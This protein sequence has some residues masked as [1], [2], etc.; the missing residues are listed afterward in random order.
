MP[1]KKS[2]GVRAEAGSVSTGRGTVR[3]IEL[4]DE[5][6]NELFDTD[7]PAL[8]ASVPLTDLLATINAE[9][10]DGKVIVEKIVRGAPDEWL[11]E[12][13]PSG[14]LNQQLQSD[15][16]AGRYRVRVYARNN[17]GLLAIRANKTI[18][19]GAL[20][21]SKE[22]GVVATQSPGADRVAE[23]MAEMRAAADKAND[24]HMTLMN[25]VIT[26]LAGNGNRN[27]LAE[28]KTFADG[29]NA[30]P[31]P[32]KE[33]NPIELLG[34]VLGLVERLKAAGGP[35][36][37]IDAETGDVGSNALLM[38]GIEVFGSVLSAAKGA[39]GA[40]QAPALAA[41]LAPASPPVAA[42]PLA[43]VAPQPPEDEDMQMVRLFVRSLV[44]AARAGQPVEAHANTVYAA[45]S[46]EALA[47]MRQ[48]SWFETLGAIEPI[49][50][51][52]RPWFAALRDEVLA[53]AAEESAAPGE[54]ADAGSTTI[55]T[56]GDIRS[57]AAGNAAAAPITAKR[58]TGGA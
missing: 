34:A 41:P 15:Y 2:N 56:H 37:P 20:P 12:G 40:P 46:D 50:A 45:L 9:G 32:A 25:T 24:R 5:M 8:N 35:A 21:K 42:I 58:K 26:A 53:Y 13:A 33:Q 47:A 52:L 27:Q 4:P 18:T 16:G 10:L 57:Q 38:K 1:R 36:L 54:A 30:L 6:P 14:D 11:F 31:K 51:D 7:A 19:I 39:Q 43:G 55:E 23:L 44:K 17:D 29:L 22:A 28:F 3:V 49:A 48:E